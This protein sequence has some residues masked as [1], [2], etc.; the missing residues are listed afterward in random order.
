MLDQRNDMTHIY[1]GDAAKRLVQKILESYIP[2]FQKMKKSVL[3]IYG[4]QLEKMA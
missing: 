3:E 4:E 1:D 2:V